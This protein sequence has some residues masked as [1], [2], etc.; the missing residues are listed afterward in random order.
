MHF[1]NHMHV[2]EFSVPMWK[3]LEFRDRRLCWIKIYLLRKLTNRM[4]VVNTRTVFLSLFSGWRYS[5]N[6]GIVCTDPEIDDMP[7]ST[8]YH[9]KYRRLIIWLIWYDIRDCWNTGYHWEAVFYS[10]L[11]KSYFHIFAYA[12]N[13]QALSLRWVSYGCH[14]LQRGPVYQGQLRTY[15]CMFLQ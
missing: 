2:L 1:E 9:L 8:S 10:Y 7:K 15:T 3:W 5:Y 4:F 6:K 11:T 13:K 14:L 12:I